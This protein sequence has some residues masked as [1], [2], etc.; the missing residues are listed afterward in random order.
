LQVYGSQYAPPSNAPTASAI[1]GTGLSVQ[2][3]SYQVTFLTQ[4]GETPPSPVVSV[5]TTSGNQQARL[6]NIPIAPAQSL[7]PTLA[8]NNVCE[9]DAA[10]AAGGNLGRMGA[11]ADRK[12]PTSTQSS[13]FTL[14]IGPTELPK[15]NTLLMRIFYATKRQLDTSGSTFPEVHRD[16]IVLGAVA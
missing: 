11:V 12:G 10:L 6:T 3:Y 7:M 9:P 4:G 15:D 1:A 14:N 5:T 13:S 2:A 16:I 8:T